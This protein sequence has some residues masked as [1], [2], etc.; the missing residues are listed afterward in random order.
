MQGPR[1]DELLSRLVRNSAPASGTFERPTS[2]AAMLAELRRQRDE[3]SIWGCQFLRLFAHGAFRHDDLKYIFSQ[4]YQYSKNFTR[5]LSAL[6]TRCTDDLARARLGQNLWDEGGGADPE[7]RHGQLFR[8]FLRHA[9]GWQDLEAVVG[10]SCT[11]HFVE[12]YLQNCLDPDVTFSSAFLSLGTESIVPRL[13]RIF[14]AGLERAGVCDEDLTFFRI[15]VE[16]DDEHAETLEQIMCSRGGEPRW[17]ETCA[18]ASK[19]AL[20]L[21][22]RFFDDL[23]KQ[24]QFRRVSTAIGRVQQHVSLAVGSEPSAL[25]QRWHEDRAVLYHNTDERLGVNFEVRALP[26]HTEVLDPRI[27][28]IAPGYRNERHR[29]AHETFYYV[30]QGRGRIFIDE[31]ELLVS[32]GDM[33]FV[34]RWSLHQT[35]NEGDETMIVLAVTDFNFTNSVHVGDHNPRWKQ[36]TNQ[37]A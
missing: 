29:H 13:Y 18:K 27:V 12:A 24:V 20:D 9:L 22:Q 14:I 6:M 28:S 8:N 32:A 34:P 1:K 25:V 30:L 37:S 36:S 35:A 5:F 11:M 10:D 26:F 4:Y 19:A 3:H 17:F 33:A 16:V 21:R 23:L 15:H 31:A 7:K 2:M